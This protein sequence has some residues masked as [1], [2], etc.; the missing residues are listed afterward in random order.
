MAFHRSD[1]IVAFSELLEQCPGSYVLLT[2]SK[3]Q[4]TFR[5]NG[6]GGVR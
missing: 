1:K 3:D 6:C 2:S 5:A 4:G